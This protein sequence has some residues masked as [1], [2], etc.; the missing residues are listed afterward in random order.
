MEPAVLQ[1]TDGTGVET[2]EA[3]DGFDAG[4]EVGLCHGRSPEALGELSARVT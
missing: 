1:D 2:V 3:A 4:S